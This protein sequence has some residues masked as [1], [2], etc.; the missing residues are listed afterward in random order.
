M[1]LISVVVLSGCTGAYSNKLTVYDFDTAVIQYELNGATQGDETL[2]IRGDESAL[3]SFVTRAEQEENKI[4]LS[5]ENAAYIADMLQMTAI[6]TTNK[7]YLAMKDLDKDAQEE[8]L[9]RKALGLKADTEIPESA[10][11]KEIAG[12]TCDIYE[13]ANIGEACIWKGIVLEKTISMAG[14]TDTKTAISIQLNVDIDGA[15]MQ[16]PSNVTLVN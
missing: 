4:T 6:K 9:I 14:V 5:L 12:Q 11:T 1:V 13:I 2:Y 16:L 3:Y 15:K 8:Y 7:D 10:S